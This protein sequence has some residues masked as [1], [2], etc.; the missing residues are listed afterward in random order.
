MN[1]AKRK[2]VQCPT[3]DGQKDP[4]AVTCISCRDRMVY[5]DQ[6]NSI[7][8]ACRKCDRTLPADQFRLRKAARKG[9]GYKRESLC[10][11]CSR[12]DG[13]IR[14]RRRHES[15][16]PWT[17][18]IAQLRHAA[19]KIWKVDPDVLVAFV[20][21]HEGRCEICGRTAEEANM[22]NRRL[23]V[24]HSSAG[25]RGMLCHHCN[26]GLGHFRDDP[27]LLLRAIMYLKQEPAIRVL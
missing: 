10:L 2:P 19:R 26:T 27:E 6:A 11:D 4:R 17:D 16:M 25:V 12:E 20:K 9:G 3:C 22:G 21:G 18:K 24:D 13:R 8:R 23:H 14:A 15:G 5:T 1:H 7:P